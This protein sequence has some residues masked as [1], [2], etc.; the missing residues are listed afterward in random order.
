MA[1]TTDDSAF[2]VEPFDAGRHDRSGFDCGV[3]Q[4]D[5]Y[6]RKTANKLA[7]AGNVRLFVLVRRADLQVAGFYATNAHAIDYRALPAK[8]A[9][10]RAAHG[11]IPAAYLSMIG[12]DRRFAGQGLGGVLLVDALMRLELASRQTGIA[13]VLL[14]IL[15]CGDPSAVERRRRLYERY[16]FI[17]LPSRPMRMFI[18]METVRRMLAAIG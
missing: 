13:V 12:V 15:D 18:A 8:Y 9:R 4:V 16:G 5:N 14:D 3:A 1:V 7:K 6:F 10:S 11:T 2:L 17:P